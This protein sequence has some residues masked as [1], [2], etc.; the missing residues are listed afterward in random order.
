M[1]DLWLGSPEG[2]PQLIKK[3]VTK[4][5]IIFYGPKSFPAIPI[6]IASSSLLTHL[7][8]LEGWSTGGRV[9]SPGRCYKTYRMPTDQEQVNLPFYKESELWV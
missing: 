9:H 1:N 4:S 2:P 7:T 3:Q 5:H 8:N 6:S